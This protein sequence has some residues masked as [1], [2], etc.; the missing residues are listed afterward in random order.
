MK[1]YCSEGAV[2]LAANSPDAASPRW[3]HRLIAGGCET[4]GAIVQCFVHEGASPITQE[5]DP[6]AAL[7]SKPRVQDGAVPC[8]RRPSV[9]MRRKRDDVWMPGTRSQTKTGRLCRCA[10]GEAAEQQE[11]AQNA[12]AQAS[13]ARRSPELHALRCFAFMAGT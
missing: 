6:Y 9:V 4:K 7:N 3:R 5:E 8:V 1:C 2:Q 11:R 12:V 13:A 10:C